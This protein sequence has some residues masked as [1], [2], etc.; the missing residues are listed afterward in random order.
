MGWNTDGEVSGSHISDKYNRLVA[1]SIQKIGLSIEQRNDLQ[2]K[3]NGLQTPYP[4]I[5]IFRIKIQ[6]PAL[7]C[8]RKAGKFL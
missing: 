4:T 7:P 1:I 2:K 3:G 5:S 6:I 8:H